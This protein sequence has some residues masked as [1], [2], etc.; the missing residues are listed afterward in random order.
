VAAGLDGVTHHDHLMDQKG[1]QETEERSLFP[2]CV[3]PAGHETRA[4]L[5]SQLA[6]HADAA[7][8]EVFHLRSRR[9]EIDGTAQ[10]D[11]IGG[12]EI[13]LGCVRGSL[14]D[15]LTAGTFHTSCDRPSELLRV[16]GATG[17]GDQNL[18]HERSPSVRN[19]LRARDSL[20]RGSAAHSTC[21]P[22]PLQQSNRAELLRDV[23]LP[24]PFKEGN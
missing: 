1:A 9:A 7:V 22:L 13:L 2:P 18:D 21:R 23:R 11:P 17:I 16:S 3:M 24:G 8:D 15:H 5:V 14:D 6:A 10:D 4:H 20:G 19:R 12:D